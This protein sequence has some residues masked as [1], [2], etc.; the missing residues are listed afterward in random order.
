MLRGSRAGRG[1]RVGA[2]WAWQ[3]ECGGVRVMRGIRS[4]SVLIGSEDREKDIKNVEVGGDRRWL[5]GFRE[6]RPPWRSPL[7]CTNL[8]WVRVLAVTITTIRE[9]RAG[10]E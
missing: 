7:S 8:D 5:R 3:S 6:Q 2:E 4:R 10:R 1:P 9:T